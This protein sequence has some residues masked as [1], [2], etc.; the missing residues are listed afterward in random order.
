MDTGGVR[1]VISDTEAAVVRRIFEMAAAGYGLTTIAKTLNGE[2]AASPRA[3]QGRPNGWAPS[4][5]REVLHRSLYRGEIVWNQS[6]K[7]DRW[8]IKRQQTRPSEEWIRVK[9]QELAIV[10]AAQWS[11]AQHQMSAHRK[12][13]GTKS[14]RK[15]IFVGRDPKYLLSGLL[16]CGVCGGGLEAR[17]RSQGGQRKVFYGCSAHHRKGT[18]VCTNSL[19]VPMDVAD[20]KVIAELK[21]SLLD[22]RVVET[23]MRRATTRLTRAAPAQG[24]LRRELASVEREL[25]NLTT[26]VAT[27]G[28]VRTLVAAMRDREARRQTILA[29]LNIIEHGT[30][31]DPKAVLADLRSRLA[32]YRALLHDEAPKARGLLK[33]LIVDRLRMEPSR[34]G[35]YRFTGTGTLLPILSGIMPVVPQSMASPTGAAGSWIVEIAGSR[36]LERPFQGIRCSALH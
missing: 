8:G 20:A 29:D 12:R 30:T 27:G 35:F 25:G 1:R 19:T 22:P 21:N 33:R 6:R 5:V 32:D 24:T 2:R 26:A 14:R 7:R 18:S 23:A 16:R 31:P 28:D 9:A 15:V 4:S 13:Y 11:A 36:C 34:G 3:Q 17:S 10:T